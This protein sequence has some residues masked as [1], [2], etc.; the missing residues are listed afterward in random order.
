M[1]RPWLFAW[2]WWRVRA[3]GLCG[4]FHVSCKLLPARETPATKTLSAATG[5]REQTL[6]PFQKTAT[7]GH[8]LS[9][10]SSGLLSDMQTLSRW[11][12]EG[13]NVINPLKSYSIS[14]RTLPYR[15]LPL[16][17]SCEASVWHWAGIFRAPFAR[18]NSSLRAFVLLCLL[19]DLF[20]CS[21]CYKDG[22]NKVCFNLSS[23]S[24]LPE[25]E[26]TTALDAFSLF[27]FGVRE[28]IR[29]QRHTGL[30]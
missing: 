18:T 22:N 9:I 16:A 3:Q 30:S 11:W 19:A 28:G 26:K 15:S 5:T 14:I 25:W 29:W 20:D 2:Y 10:S 23:V 27:F 7:C 13:S 4:Q 24:H 6:H 17:Y 21:A 8:C 12:S 1:A